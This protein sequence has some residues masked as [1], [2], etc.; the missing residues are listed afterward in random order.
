MH[1]VIDLP[2]PAG[3]SFDSVASE[4]TYPP[5]GG[6]AGCRLRGRT[7]DGHSLLLDFFAGTANPLLPPRLDAVHLTRD[8]ADP[9][10]WQIISTQGRYELEAARL[11]VHED[12]MT[13]A[14]A[15]LPPRPVPLIRRAF[16]RLMFLV[17]ALPF[18]RRWLERRVARSASS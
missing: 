7:P 6:S 15:V 9:S 2:G 11:F 18:G 12:I 8:A 16:W 17:L 4:V 14:A 1:A 13:R 10:H 5:A 3:F